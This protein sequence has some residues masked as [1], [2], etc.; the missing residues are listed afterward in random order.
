VFEEKSLEQITPSGEAFETNLKLHIT[1][2]HQ[3]AFMAQ[4]PKLCPG[5]EL[6]QSLEVFSGA[7]EGADEADENESG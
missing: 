2:S 3:A 7:C 1:A 4:L 5:L 6:G